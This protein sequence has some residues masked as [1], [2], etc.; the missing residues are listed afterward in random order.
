MINVRAAA[1]ALLMLASLVCGN[2]ARSQKFAELA[3]TPPMGW[4]SWNHYAC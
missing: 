2:P 4:N 3:Q 1:T